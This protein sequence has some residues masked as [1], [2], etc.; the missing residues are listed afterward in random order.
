[1]N[2]VSFIFGTR[3]E[4]IKMAPIIL[5]LSKS[6]EF[7]LNIC[8]TGQHKEMLDQVLQIF[9]IV[10]N[11]DLKL[12]KPNQTLSSVTADALVGLDKYFKMVRP[13]IVLV[14]GDTTSAFCG[15]LA[16]FYHKVPVAHVE[17][18]LRTG[19]LNS[20]WPEEANRALLSRIAALHFAPTKSAADNLRKEGIERGSISITG[21]TVI[22]ALKYAQSFVKTRNP[23]V[24]GIE[25]NHPLFATN[26]AMVL[27]T[28]HRR[29]SFGKGFQ[30]ICQAIRKLAETFPDVW[31]V[32]PVHLNPN[33]QVPVEQIL[34][35]RKFKNIKLVPPQD[36][37]SFIRLMDRSTIVLT[38]SG[39]V[40][41]EAP[42]LGKP[43]LVMR[44]N[45]ERMEGVASG[46]VKLVGTDADLIFE[47]TAELLRDEKAYEKM[48]QTKNPY[49]D[50]KASQR[51]IQKIQEFFHSGKCS[52]A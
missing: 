39:G 42:S 4:A 8:V 20:P 47:K 45:S 38:D 30:S 7:S 48:A 2:T 51:I 28:G 9:G 21:N 25:T 17:A 46:I 44:E 40:Q 50:G 24:R 26:A 37:L 1:M 5:Q 15:G 35:K 41:E 19:N 18:G 6:K 43:V 23:E 14:Q 31:F 34:G 49:G 12:M 29:E 32:Y 13:Q 36:Y 3:P 52:I 22:D 11:Y 10:P 33:V 16:A 27:I